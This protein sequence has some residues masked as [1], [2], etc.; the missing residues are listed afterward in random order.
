MG[1]GRD[2]VG[3]HALNAAL[4]CL[5]VDR[6][7]HGRTPGLAAKALVEAMPRH[8]PDSF[9]RRRIRAALVFQ[10]GKDLGDDPAVLELQPGMLA[11]GTTGPNSLVQ[12]G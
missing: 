5:V 4:T 2:E 10:I 1:D 12:A 9:D 7:D 11:P 8:A 3:L 6:E